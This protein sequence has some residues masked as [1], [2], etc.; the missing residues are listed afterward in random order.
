VLQTARAARL[1]RPAA[2]LCARQ[3]VASPPGSYTLRSSGR[4]VHVRHRSRDLDILTEVFGRGTYAPPYAARSVLSSPLDVLDLGGNVGL[5]GLYALDR[6]DV[7]SLCSYEPDRDNARLLEETARP[8]DRWTVVR[9]AASNRAGELDFRGGLFSE[10]RMALPGEPATTVPAHDVLAT[11][12]AD[13]VKIDIEGGEWAILA[14]PR[15]PRTSW[16]AVVIEWHHLA[17]PAGDDAGAEASRLLA[18][19]GF[20]QQARGDECPTNGLLWAWRA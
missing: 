1:V 17:C 14:D 8:Y 6:F 7:R 3:A 11:C 16:R 18:A 5:F 12:P 9:A 4:R 2:Q 15:L 13:L 20:T 19:A 10:S